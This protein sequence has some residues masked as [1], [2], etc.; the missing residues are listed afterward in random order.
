MRSI[1][2]NSICELLSQAKNRQPFPHTKSDQHQTPHRR[3]GTNRV[4]M[5]YNSIIFVGSVRRLLSR[6]LQATC[7]FAAAG[8][9]LGAGGSVRAAIL[10][11]DPN[12]TAGAAVGG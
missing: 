9:F 1:S 5:K 2:S 7:T 11:W 4:F 12:V 8:L 10:S 3:E 6:T